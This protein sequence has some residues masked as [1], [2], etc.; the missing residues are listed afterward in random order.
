MELKKMKKYKL[1]LLAMV[2]ALVGL[3]YLSNAQEITVPD[4]CTPDCSAAEW[5]SV[6]ITDMTL[7][8]M[9]SYKVY[10]VYRFAC[11]GLYQDIQLLKVEHWRGSNMPCKENCIQRGWSQ[12]ERYKAAL[13]AIIAKNT[14]GFNPQVLST[15]CN[16]TWRVSSKTCWAD[17][18]IVIYKPSQGVTDTLDVIVACDSSSC[19]LTNMKVCRSYPNG[20]EKIEITNLGPSQ[21]VYCDSYMQVGNQIESCVGVCDWLFP[22][23]NESIF[24]YDPSDWAIVIPKKANETEVHSYQFGVNLLMSNGMLNFEIYTDQSTNCNLEIYDL[25]GKRVYNS[26]LNLNSGIQKV[27]IDKNLLNSNKT[28]L[29]QFITN[30][31]IIKTGKFIN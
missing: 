18:E 3:T 13:Q 22:G 9:G 2:T 27:S 11:N 20:K 4:P 10:W 16:S 1:F 24:N 6:Q 8:C 5:S 21:N 28:Y 23:N 14:M 31:L 19:C 12:E 30:G 17:F 26:S 29:Y 15:G 7:C 25:E